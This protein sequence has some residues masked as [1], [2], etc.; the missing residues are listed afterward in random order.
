MSTRLVDPRS[1]AALTP[2]PWW[3]RVEWSSTLWILFLLVPFSIVVLADGL[4]ASRR[5]CG[6][7]GVTSFAAVYAWAVSTSPPWHSVPPDASLSEQLAPLLPGLV[8][9]ALTTALSLPGLGWAT[10]YYLPFLYAFILFTT[11]AR[12][13]LPVVVA[14]NACAL[15]AALML[16]PTAEAMWTILGSACATPTIIFARIGDERSRRRL[17]AEEELNVVRQRERI[18]RDV[19]D[20]LGH[21]LTVLTLKAQVARRLVERDPEAAVRELDEI[22]SL[23]RSSL[24]DVRATV[25]RLRTPDLASQ[26]EASRTALRAAE[27]TVSLEGDPQAVPSGQRDTLA[28][29]LRETT[30]NV[31]RHAGAG[32]VRITLAPGLLRVADDGVGLGGAV[33]GNGLSGLRQRVEAVEGS[34]SV[35]SPD[36]GTGR[37]TLVEVRLP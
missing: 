1:H 12:T 6:L 18:G 25:T 14:A 15:W 4:S 3:R 17:A 21:S 36:P 28:W 33:P 32:H 16:T 24:A 31:V 26:V 34:L 7:V 35:T 11:P 19:H 5:A 20:I 30:T 37:G 29:A 13:S 9:M 23:A 22:I 8:P 27:V 10:G 2:G